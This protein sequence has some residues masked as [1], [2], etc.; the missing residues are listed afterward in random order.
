MP[1]IILNFYRSF[2]AAAANKG[3]PVFWDS[4]T[5]H[6]IAMNLLPSEKDGHPVTLSARKD[7]RDS[8]A[9]VFH[10]KGTGFLELGG[11]GP[12]NFIQQTG[13]TLSQIL[14]INFEGADR[15]IQI[16]TAI[17][18]EGSLSGC[19]FGEAVTWGKY[20]KVDEDKLIQIWAEYSIVFPLLTAYVVNTC[21]PKPVKNLI[22]KMPDIIQNLEKSQ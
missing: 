5:N 18:R 17:E 7:I 15:G 10:A 16:G 13:P 3:V 20:K 6:S 11:G 4:H 19:T 2:T 12:K 1:S 9:I 14:G 8:A 22:A 21:K